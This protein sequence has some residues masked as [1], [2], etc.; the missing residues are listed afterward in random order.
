MK[1]AAPVAAGVRGYN[2]AVVRMLAIAVPTLGLLVVMAVLRVADLQWARD[3]ALK[4]AEQRTGN[5][6][7]VASAWLASRFE[8]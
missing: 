3:E 6:A 8:M 2:T 5:L 7:I 4:A 1:P